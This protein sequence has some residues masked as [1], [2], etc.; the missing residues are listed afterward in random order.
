MPNNVQ[1]SEHK[2]HNVIDLI[3]KLVPVSDHKV[4]QS[5]AG[6]TSIVSQTILYASRK[7]KEH[8]KPTN[9]LIPQ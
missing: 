8:E 1:W 7:K 5:G 2:C 9:S 4:T 3:S 6:K